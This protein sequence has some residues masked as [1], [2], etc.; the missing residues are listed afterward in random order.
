MVYFHPAKINERN[1]LRIG[2]VTSLFWRAC[3]DEEDTMWLE[4][5]SLKMQ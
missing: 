2:K 3:L 5:E 1:I 4:I